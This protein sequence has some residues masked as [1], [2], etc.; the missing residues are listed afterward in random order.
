MDIFNYFEK[1][2]IDTLDKSF[3]RMIAVWE[4]ARLFLR[5][6]SSWLYWEI[7]RVEIIWKLR[8]V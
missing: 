3:Y 8:K 6:Q 1:K 2:G 5:D 4:V 7:K